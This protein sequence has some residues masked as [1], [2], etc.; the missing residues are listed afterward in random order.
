[1]NTL[2]LTGMLLGT[3]SAVTVG[4]SSH[5][6]RQEEY[7]T[8]TSTKLEMARMMAESK[9]IIDFKGTDSGGKEFHLIVNLPM[10]MP[11]IQQIKQDEAYAFWGQILGSSIP[12]LG[13]FATSWIGSYYNYKNNEAMWGALG[14]SIG[15]G[16]HVGGNATITNSNNKLRMESN[17]GGI[18]ASDFLTNTSITETAPEPEPP[19]PGPAPRPLRTKTPR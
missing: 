12:V 2:K 8:Y 7:N 11:D 16:I 6:Q 1:M 15:G 18:S 17:G 5:I 19:A 14:D 13:S 10:Q 9:P 3:F 4:C